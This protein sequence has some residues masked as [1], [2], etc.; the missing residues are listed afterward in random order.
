MLP[1]LGGFVLLVALPL[2]FIAPAVVSLTAWLITSVLWGTHML[3]HALLV[4]L[5]AR[6]A[7]VLATGLAGIGMMVRIWITMTVIFVI[8][9]DTVAGV[10][11]GFARPDLA[12]TVLLLFT[13]AFTVDVVVR[14]ISEF[15]RHSRSAAAQ[16]RGTP[17]QEDQ[18]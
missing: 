15:Q 11:V 5:G 6:L 13:A 9:V 10:S 1:L 18:P 8:G 16:R 2:V 7:P 4:G 17:A 3:M 12:V 14:T